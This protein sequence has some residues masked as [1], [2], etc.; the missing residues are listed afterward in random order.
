MTQRILE[1][2][3]YFLTPDKYVWSYILNISI[4]LAVKAITFGNPHPPQIQKIKVTF[5]WIVWHFQKWTYLLWDYCENMDKTGEATAILM[6][7]I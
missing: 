2:Y 1:N 6:S 4:D 5:N 3:F 7:L